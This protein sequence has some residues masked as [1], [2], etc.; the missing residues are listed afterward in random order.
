[1]LKFNLCIVE[2]KCRCKEC[3][4]HFGSVRTDARASFGLM[5]FP[6]V[7][8]TSLFLGK[9]E[10]DKLCVYMYKVTQDDFVHFKVGTK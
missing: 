2:G 10:P 5:D 9:R 3:A 8:I 7:N 6:V 4:F 1:M